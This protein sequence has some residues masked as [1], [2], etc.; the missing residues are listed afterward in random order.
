MGFRLFLFL[1]LFSGLSAC[2]ES[3][4][5]EANA[6]STD[7]T[8]AV[9]PVDTT[10]EP[11]LLIEEPE[12]IISE[13]EQTFIDSGLIDLHAMD[14]RIVVDLKYSSTDNFMEMD[15]YGDLNRAYL[16][17]EAAKKLKKAQDLLEEM[18]PGFAL[19]VY[20]GARPRRVQKRMWDSLDIPF[21]R[22][23]VAPPW[24]GSIHNYGCAVD[25]SVLDES[26]KPLDMGTG[27]DF[28]GKEAQPQLESRMLKEGKITLEHINNR[29][30]L[31]SVMLKA[32]FY[33]IRTEW[34]HFNAFPSKTVKSRFGII[35]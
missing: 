6:G 8:Q 23:Y 29:Q 34:W 18:H 25:L 15:M 30:L 10:P 24:E 28:F 20:D 12:P 19:I 33:N 32:G 26:G 3:E 21:K 22:N 17:P 14:E 35:E 4:S 11:E 13:Y 5:G 9:L 1:F 2:S 27:Y 16:R 7:S 31:K